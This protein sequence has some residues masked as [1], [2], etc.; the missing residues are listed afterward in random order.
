MT[1]VAAIT[2]ADSQLARCLRAAGAPPG[3][4]GRHLLRAS[5]DI[6]EARQVEAVLDE[7]GPDC[8]INT[9]AY[10][11]VDQAERDAAQARRVNAE[12]VANL[13]RWCARREAR[14]IHVST[15]FVFDGLATA[16]YAPE[17][18]TAPLGEYGLGK[19][20]GEREVA[21][22]PPGQGAVLRASW[23]YSEFGRN[24]VKTMLSLM[25]ERDELAVVDDQTGCPTSAHSLAAL[26]LR[27]LARPARSGLYHWHDGGAM[28]WREFAL[29][30]QRQGQA[31][32]VLRNMIPIRPIASAD[33][34]A[35]AKRPAYSVMDRSRALREFDMP[36]GDW[37]AELTRVVGAIAT[38]DPR[39]A[40]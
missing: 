23:L 22:L 40:D 37:R 25:A 13:V 18:A 10:T 11:A 5:L 12:G 6:T 7:I 21:K 31:A 17:D 15:D 34:P 33:Y 16:P 20:L 28:S 26:I 38:G 39:P 30:I 19:L 4:S 8:V 35:A 24:F 32:G 27:M 9:A 3:W 29:E 2:G 14:L 36:E 1:A